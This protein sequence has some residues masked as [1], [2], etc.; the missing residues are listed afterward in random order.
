MTRLADVTQ[1]YGF[2]LFTER[3]DAFVAERTCLSGPVFSRGLPTLGSFAICAEIPIQ[4]FN[5]N[6]GVENEAEDIHLAPS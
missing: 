6:C 4:G 1:N 5:Q 2:M 3:F